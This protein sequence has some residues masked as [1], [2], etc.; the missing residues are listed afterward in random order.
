MLVLLGLAQTS[1][2]GPFT[3]KMGVFYGLNFSNLLSARKG[4]IFVK[5][6]TF[7]DFYM[8]VPTLRIGLYGDA[9]SS[10]PF[11]ISSMF[12]SVCLDNG[13]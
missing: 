3:V 11:I 2:R 1:P 6:T 13:F 8:P 7:A 5:S 4:I 10:S 12:V 9:N